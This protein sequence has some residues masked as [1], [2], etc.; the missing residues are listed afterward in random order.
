M[1][2]VVFDLEIDRKIF[3]VENAVCRLEM[4]KEIGIPFR[5]EVD[6][7]ALHF[8]EV[9]ADSTRNNGIDVISLVIRLN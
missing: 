2:D 5:E 3:S 9:L 1:F 8:N 6:L 4:K 7:A